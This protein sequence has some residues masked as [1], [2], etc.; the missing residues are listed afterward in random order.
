MPGAVPIFL[1]CHRASYTADM[2]NQP[3]HRR[4][5]FAVSGLLTALRSESSLR[6]QI[7]AAL[8]VFGI[9]VW[10]QP[11]PIWWALLA[12]TIGCV[13]ATEL[14]NTAVEHLADHLHPERHPTIKIVKDCAAA[15]VLV[16][17]LAA[18]GVAAALVYE[19]VSG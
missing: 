14:L 1:A 16:A 5:R 9:L 4:L 18:L 7:V 13:L 2:K 10:L 11:T 12:L 8:A 17:S 15:A 3:F 19:L 6:L